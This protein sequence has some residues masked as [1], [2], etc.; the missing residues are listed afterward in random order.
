M[1]GH[2][3]AEYAEDDIRLP[4][5]VG[6]GRCD[7]VGQREVEDREVRR[8]EALIKRLPGG[9]ALLT[10]QACN[11]S[12]VSLAPVVYWSPDDGHNNAA[13]VLIENKQISAPSYDMA[14]EG[15]TFTC[16]SSLAIQSEA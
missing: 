13:A 8:R 4:L 12:S 15:Y 16:Y 5:D 11:Q 9:F 1:E 10:T 7:E 14:K 2:D 6:E 3:G